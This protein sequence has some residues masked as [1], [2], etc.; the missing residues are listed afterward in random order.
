MAIATVVIEN[1][2]TIG[3]T[4]CITVYKDGK[5]HLEFLTPRKNDYV[6]YWH[7]EGIHCTG[8]Q[9]MSSGNTGFAITWPSDDKEECAR[10]IAKRYRVKYYGREAR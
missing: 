4:G 5:L 7:G 10:Y 6:E 8:R 3:A 2:V 1:G 9:L